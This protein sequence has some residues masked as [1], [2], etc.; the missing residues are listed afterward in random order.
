[1]RIE[2]FD[3]TIHVNVWRLGLVIYRP[4]Y[5]LKVWG[6]TDGDHAPALQ[7]PFFRLYYTDPNQYEFYGWLC[8]CG[9]WQETEFHCN[10]CQR[11]PPWGCDCPTH[12]EDFIDGDDYY[13]SEYP[14]DRPA[15]NYHA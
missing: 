6:L 7:T 15:R 8:A 2:K 11:E 3:C 5:N 4:P 12:D 13:P 14:V 10:D 9:N 1:M